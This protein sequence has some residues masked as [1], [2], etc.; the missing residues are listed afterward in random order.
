M[1]YYHVTTKK[2]LDKIK[3]EGLQ[4]QIGQR[5]QKIGEVFPAIY[6]FT[7]RDDMED[8]IYNWLGEELENEEIYS[9]KIDLPKGFPLDEGVQGDWE[10]RSYQKIPMEYVQAIEA[11]D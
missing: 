9:L 7:T 3:K 11:I 10:V 8:A 6:L 4:P 1:I 2:A 5:S